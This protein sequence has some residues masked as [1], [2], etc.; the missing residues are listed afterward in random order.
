[1]YRPNFQPDEKADQAEGPL[2]A[3]GGSELFS[4]LKG[5]RADMDGARVLD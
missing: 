1:M 4:L 3:T 2:K 5:M